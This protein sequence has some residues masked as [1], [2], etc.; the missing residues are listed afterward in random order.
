MDTWRGNAGPTLKV[1]DLKVLVTKTN[2]NETM[3]EGDFVNLTCLNRC[4]ARDPASA[5]TWFKNGEPINEGPALYLSNISPANSGNYTCSLKTQAG[6]SSG[7]MHI[8]VEYGPKN[9]TVSVSSSGADTDSN[10]TL[11][12]SSHSNPPVAN[13]TWFK[14]DADIVE[15][16]HQP[17]FIPGDRGQY[18][19]S[20]TN[21][22]GSQ[23]SSTVNL[24]TES[25]WT[26]F[27]RDIL[28]TATVVAVAL[29]LSVTTVTAVRRLSKRSMWAPKTDCENITQNSD[30]VNWFTCD[31]QLHEGIKCGGGT[32]DLIYSTLDLKHTKNNMGQ[33]M[34][35]DE[36]VIYSIVC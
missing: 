12:C 21:K 28:I 10:I 5:F 30:Y 1:V 15:V 32:T 18:L 25:Y 22:H 26:V 16:G 2:G 6:T 29:L 11:V 20:V 13:Y 33:Q 3:K 34:D 9:T 7:V 31:N 23:N 17:I 14:I 35:S 19:C 36:D 24:K 4:D 8:D 27:T